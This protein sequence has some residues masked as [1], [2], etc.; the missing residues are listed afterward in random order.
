R[1]VRAHRSGDEEAERARR[2]GPPA[3]RHA[4]HAR[5]LCPLL[6]APHVRLAAFAN[7]LTRGD[8][9]RVYLERAHAVRPADPELSYLL[10]LQCYQDGQHAD[11]WRF[12]REALE[13]S[14]KHL[15]EVV[16]RSARVLSPEAMIDEVLPRRPEPVCR[17]AQL[18]FPEEDDPRRRVFWERAVP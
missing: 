17:A 2:Y 1:I 14:D 7:L 10:G 5:S 8:P 4:L 3:L 6:P 13:Q 15:P 12:W 9:P 11:A 16:E 18:L